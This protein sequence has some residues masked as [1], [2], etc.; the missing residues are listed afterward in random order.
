M[1]FCTKCGRLLRFQ[2]TGP[3]EEKKVKCS[4]GSI[5]E[6][7]S[8]DLIQREKQKETKKIEI[9]DDKDHLA[10]HKN[11]C[12]KCGYDR[13]QLIDIAPFYGDEEPIIRYKCGKCKYVE[14]KSSTSL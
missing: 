1:H 7:H 6:F 5:Q 9:I 3:Q 2:N 13:A 10:V 11:I 4:C 8:N 14:Q 12:P